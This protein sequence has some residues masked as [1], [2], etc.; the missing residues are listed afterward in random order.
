V[1]NSQD[2]KDSRKRQ[3]SIH[4]ITTLKTYLES[5]RANGAKIHSIPSVATARLKDGAIDEL[6]TAWLDE[7]AKPDVKD[8]PTCKGTGWN[9]TLYIES[10]G[11]TMERCDHRALYGDREGSA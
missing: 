4:S 10:D 11:N 3:D 9:Q 7:K 2:S 6:V 5:Q 1:N 8:C